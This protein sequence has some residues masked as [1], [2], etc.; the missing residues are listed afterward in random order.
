MKLHI[1]N[2]LHPNEADASRKLNS[3]LNTFSEEALLALLEGKIEKAPV[4]PNLMSVCELFIE[5]AVH[6]A[7]Y[8]RRDNEVTPQWLQR[9]SDL[10]EFNRLADA[11]GK[12]EW[13]A[14]AKLS[15]NDQI[16]RMAPEDPLKKKL[17]ILVAQGLNQVL[18]QL[19]DE[20]EAAS[21]TGSAPQVQADE[22]GVVFQGLGFDVVK[23]EAG[24]I[25]KYHEGSS[26]VIVVHDPRE[27][28]FL[29]VEHKCPLT[30]AYLLE[31]PRTACVPQGMIETALNTQL[32]SQTGLV[33]KA[34]ELIGTL[35]PEPRILIGSCQVYY[36]NFDLEENHT[37]ESDAVR[38]LKRI[39]AEGLYQAAYE[40]RVTCSLTLGA[41]SIWN[42]FNIVRKKRIANS[43]RVRNR[44]VDDQEDED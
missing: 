21:C 9:L 31:F 29:L 28:Q 12:D 35:S 14:L 24:L 17:H 4:S 33:D 38:S 15:Y 37:Q 40:G 25:A 16:S 13:L 43:N 5:I 1:A 2:M 20:L 23:T 6:L 7:I 41:M 19:L 11:H 27:D 26:A 44:N 8:E 3:I 22:K 34:F 42:A 30:G 18:N 39:S 32:R 10:G 36:T